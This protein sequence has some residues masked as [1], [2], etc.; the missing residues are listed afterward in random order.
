V[1]LGDTHFL[2][3]ALRKKCLAFAKDGEAS[4]PLKGKLAQ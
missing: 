4:H 3:C 2:A 1:K